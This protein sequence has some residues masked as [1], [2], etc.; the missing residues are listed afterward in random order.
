MIVLIYQGNGAYCYANSASMLLSRIGEEIS[1]SYIEVLTGFSL[2]ASLSEGGMIFFDNGSSSPAQG[3]NRAFEI[4][5]FRVIEKVREEN[6][7]IPL[8]ERAFIVVGY[9]QNGNQIEQKMSSTR[10]L[11][12]YFN[13]PITNSFKQNLGLVPIGASFFISYPE[14]DD[15][16]GAHPRSV[17]FLPGDK[18]TR[19]MFMKLMSAL[20]KSSA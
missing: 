8:G 20:L 5:G 14:S 10:R 3:L 1:P 7:Q 6:K 13:Y 15:L 16:L 19:H 11:Y 4:L 18:F 9:P 17:K 2:G 12:S